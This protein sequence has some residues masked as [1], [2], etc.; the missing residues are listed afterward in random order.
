V[1]CYTVNHN[2]AWIAPGDEWQRVIA[3]VELEEQEGL[4]VVTNIVGCADD[5]V[6]TGM[7]V[8]VQFH[9]TDDVFLPVFRPRP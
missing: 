3:L 8:E 5:E 4:R 2:Q 1:Y 9:E 6:H 7:P